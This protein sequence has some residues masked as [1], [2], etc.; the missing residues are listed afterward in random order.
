MSEL[1]LMDREKLTDK[2]INKSGKI[3]LTIISNKGGVGKTSIAVCFGFYFANVLNKKTLLVELDSSP[4][5][6]G[7]LFDIS[8]DNSLDIA[9]KFPD[10]FKNYIKS[11]H[12]NLDVLKGFSNPINAE[13]VT[14]IEFYALIHNISEFYEVIIFDTQTVLNG[15]IIDA[16]KFSNIIIL[17]SEPTIES[18]SRISELI[19][20]LNSKF[21]INK[22]KFHLVIN[23]KKILDLFKIKDI[24]R[25]LDFPVEGFISYDKRFNKNLIIF[26][27]NKLFKSKFNIQIS[28]LIN[29]LISSGAINEFAGKA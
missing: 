1:N 21:L 27:T 11:I 2:N 14:E 4:G 7:P 20:I 25:I 17:L 10:R 19:S 15:I 13:A 16:L 18:L 3:F 5:D 8:G 24:A 26:N 12:K 9:I 28:K 22:D 6:F 29:N 23:K